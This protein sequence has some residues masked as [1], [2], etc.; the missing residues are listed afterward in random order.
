MHIQ[1]DYI[2]NDKKKG[3]ALGPSLVKNTIL[4]DT[5]TKHYYEFDN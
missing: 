4:F 3:K 1:E 5:E 2:Y